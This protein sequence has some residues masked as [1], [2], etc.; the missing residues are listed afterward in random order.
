MSALFI[1]FQSPAADGTYFVIL[2]AILA[3]FMVACILYVACTLQE[4]DFIKMLLLLFYLLL[5]F[6][7]FVES[8]VAYVLLDVH[9]LISLSRMLSKLLSIFIAYVPGLVI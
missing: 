7:H 3:H 1:L 5:S 2:A 6:G 9:S 4:L 8:T